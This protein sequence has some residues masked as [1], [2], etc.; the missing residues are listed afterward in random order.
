MEISGGFFLMSYQDFILSKSQWRHE[1][2]FEPTSTPDFLFDFQ[3]HLF[4]YACRK[5]RAAIF[6]DCGLGKTAIELAFG[7]EIVQRENKPVLLLTPLAVGQQILLEAEKFGVDAERCRDANCNYAPKIWITNYEQLTKFDSSKFSA[8]ICDESSRIKDAKSATKH[9]VTEFARRIKYRLLC[10]ATAAPNDFH[11]LGTSSEALGLLGFRDMIT[12]FF[13]QEVGKDGR[14]WG[15]TKYRFRGH[16]MEPF[17]AWV[18]SW[19][20][21]CRKPSDLG[22][23]DSKFVLPPLCEREF[24]V[25]T[26]KTR[27]GMLFAMPGVTLQDERAERRNSIRERC[28][29]AAQIASDHIEHSVIWC[30]LNDE[31]DELQKLLP[32]AKQIKGSMPDELKEE[33]LQAFSS[34]QIRQ[35]ITKPKIGAWGLNWQHCN[36]SIHLPSHSYEQYYQAVRRFWRFGQINPVKVSLIVNEGESGVLESLRRKT[37]QVNYMFESIVKHMQDAMH[38]ATNDFFPEKERLPK[39]LAQ[40]SL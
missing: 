28:D 20:R 25:A 13:K 11:E 12:T 15:R 35:L 9:D 4:E 6:A 17:W 21:S 16:A 32:E 2:G 14:G 1:A 38:L 34:G 5:G 30:E 40:T 10:T 27:P 31:G 18:C 3:R 24:V 33:Y 23:D 39:W 36:N 37:K 22:F 8:V 19:A 29:M 26:A 7:N